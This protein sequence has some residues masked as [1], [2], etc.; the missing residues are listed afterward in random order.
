MPCRLSIA[1]QKAPGEIVGLVLVLGGTITAEHGVGQLELEWGTIGI[2]ELSLRLHR[3]IKQVFDP[4]GDL[5]PG[6]GF[7]YPSPPHAS[8]RDLAQPVC[9]R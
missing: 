8:A 9:T 1:A 3:Q 7:R 4:A 2:G 6:R 5:S